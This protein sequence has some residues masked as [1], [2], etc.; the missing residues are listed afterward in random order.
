M[1]HVLNIL[2]AAVI[3]MFVFPDAGDAAK[4]Q[5]KKEKALRRCEINN[6]N[7]SNRC[8]TLIDIDNAIRD[9]ENQCQIKFS[10]CILR[11]D[12][13][14]PTQSQPGDANSDVP[15]LSTE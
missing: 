12:Q 13:L 1:K 7:C 10:R 14:G 5:T 3:L 11:A 4:K 15:V 9:C 2:L 6:I 8:A